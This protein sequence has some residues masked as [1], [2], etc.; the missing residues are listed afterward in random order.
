MQSLMMSEKNGIFPL[1]KAND[2][3][4]WNVIWCQLNLVHF[5]R[6]MHALSSAGLIQEDISLTVAPS[7][8]WRSRKQKD[9][10]LWMLFVVHIIAKGMGR[11]GL[12]CQAD[13]KR[14]TTKNALFFARFIPYATL[15]STCLLLTRTYELVVCRCNHE[16]ELLMA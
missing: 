7:R 3:L 11:R 10:S 16:A 1:L 12:F 4:D 15:A 5:V 9:I 2:V 8:D 6:L 14:G 13:T